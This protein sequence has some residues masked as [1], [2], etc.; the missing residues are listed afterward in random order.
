MFSQQV[1][2]VTQKLILLLVLLLV[3]VLAVSACTGAGG[4]TAPGD[5]GVAPIETPVGGGTLAPV[6]PTAEGPAVVEPT[7]ETQ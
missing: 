4:G 3:V 7:A 2:F 6:E 1:K 5:D